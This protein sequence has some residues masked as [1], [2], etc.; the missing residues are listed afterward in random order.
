MKTMIAALA[1]AVCATAAVSADSSAT[2]R[3]VV[4]DRKTG[5]PIAGV[6]IAVASPLGT[7]STVTNEHGAYVLWDVP[8]GMNNLT[9]LRN[10]FQS[11][12]ATICMQPGMLRTIPIEMSDRMVNWGALSQAIRSSNLTQTTNATTLGSCS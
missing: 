1:L 2:L 11:E 5:A 7:V 9:I 4:H 3:G 10:G 6:T 8:A 12:A